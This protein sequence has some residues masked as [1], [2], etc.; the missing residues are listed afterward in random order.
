MSGAVGSFTPDLEA[1]SPKTWTACYLNVSLFTNMP[2][3]LRQTDET[4]A[5]PLSILNEKSVVPY[6]A[7]PKLDSIPRSFHVVIQLKLHACSH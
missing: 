6:F 1:P 3:R 7:Q 4:T 5:F 2:S